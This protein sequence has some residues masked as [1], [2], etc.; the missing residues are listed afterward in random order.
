MCAG[1]RNGLKYNVITAD[2]N[3]YPELKSE[4]NLSNK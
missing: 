4:V 2:D 1:L 3:K